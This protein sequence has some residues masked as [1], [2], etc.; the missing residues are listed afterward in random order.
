MSHTE[1]ITIAQLASE[2]GQQPFE[3][4]A[5]LDLGKAPDDYEI[6]E[7][8]AREVL[9]LLAAEVADRA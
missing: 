6:E 3:I 1:T 5:A 8:Y 4:A 2:Y 9:D 7:G